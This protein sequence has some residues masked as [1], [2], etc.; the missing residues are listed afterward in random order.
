MIHPTHPHTRSFPGAG[1]GFLVGYPAPRLV[2]P[3]YVGVAGP[4]G[5]VAAPAMPP[6]TGSV[7]AGPGDGAEMTGATAAALSARAAAASAASAAAASAAVSAMSAHASAA[8]TA[9]AA[10]TAAVT[11]AATAAASAAA[12]PAQVAPGP[13]PRSFGRG[14]PSSPTEVDDSAGREFW[15][16]Q[17]RGVSRAERDQ[18]LGECSA[19]HGGDTQ[20]CL[21]LC[22]DGPDQRFKL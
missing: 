3:A 22:R 15:R 9:L 7:S 5:P 2:G 21:R 13:L 16:A 6:P 12:S 1:P 4:F 11:A 20:P 19:C 14:E 10:A 18:V 8:G 17:L